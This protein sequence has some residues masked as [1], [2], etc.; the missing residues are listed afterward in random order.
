MFALL[1][2][3]VVGAD[4]RAITAD[5]VYAY[6][7]QG[8]KSP[9]TTSPGMRKPGAQPVAA[10][11]AHHSRV[12][13]VAEIKKACGEPSKRSTLPTGRSRELELW[14]WEFETGIVHARFLVEHPGRPSDPDSMRVSLFEPVTKHVPSARP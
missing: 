10:K 7:M 6:L 9:A 3:C 14:V 12:F 1:L 2:A 8:Y 13:T 11:P 4:D 5:R